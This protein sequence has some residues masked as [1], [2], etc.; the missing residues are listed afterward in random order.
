M[1]FCRR[2]AFSSLLDLPNANFSAKRWINATLISSISDLF[3][4]SSSPSKIRNQQSEL[5]PAPKNCENNCL[6]S[7]SVPGFF[8]FS[9]RGTQICS[10][11]FRKF[12]FS[13]F[14]KV[15]FGRR[16]R[17]FLREKSFKYLFYRFMEY[18]K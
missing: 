13:F 2:L 6:I 11:L 3:N 12:R 16:I 7:D 1:T 8:M 17:D 4:I 15:A 18:L 14:R 9:V 5:S 10:L